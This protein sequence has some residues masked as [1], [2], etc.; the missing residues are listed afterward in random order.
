M[1]DNFGFSFEAHQLEQLFKALG[2]VSIFTI[3]SIV[4]SIMLSKRLLESK[5]WAFALHVEEKLEEGFIG[6]DA[7]INEN[8]G[9]TGECKTVLRPSG[10]V[11]IDGD[12]YD[13]VSL[14]G[15]FI[16]KGSLVKVIKFLS[17]QIYVEEIEK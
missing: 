4:L 2:M 9:K 16:E 5:K 11:V 3:L 6:V 8:I 12:L 1:I 14:H 7:A 15:E 10:K 13:A 17:G